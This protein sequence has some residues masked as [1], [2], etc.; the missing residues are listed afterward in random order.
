MQKT[1]P[2]GTHTATHSSKSMEGHSSIIEGQWYRNFRG[3]LWR[4]DVRMLCMWLSNFY[5]ER[6]EELGD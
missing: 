5:L 1:V 6:K 3:H 4:V 2:Q